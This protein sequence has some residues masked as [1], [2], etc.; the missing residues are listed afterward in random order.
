[1]SLFLGN[2]SSHVHPDE[3]ERVFRRFG[4][5]DVQLK[6]GYGFAV[7]E[8]PENAERA[9]RALRGKQICGQSIAIDWSKKQPRPPFQR[10]PR[11]RRPYEPNHGRSFHEEDNA[12]SYRREEKAASTTKDAGPR[13]EGKF[14]RYEP[15][16][17]T[18][19][20][21]GEKARAQPVCY[22][23]GLKG[24]K[25]RFCP[26]ADRSR[27]DGFA[28]FWRREDSLSGPAERTRES[29]PEEEEEEEESHKQRKKSRK[30]R[31]FRRGREQSSEEESSSSSGSV[32]RRRR[33]SKAKTRSLSASV[34]DV[35]AGSAAIERQE[36]NWEE[37]LTKMSFE[38][39]CAAL[40]HYYGSPA[41]AAAATSS[42]VGRYFGAARLWPWEMVFYRRLKKDPPSPQHR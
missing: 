25:M 12:R 20:S 39:M 38:E 26:R 21:P 10:P 32:T 11:E 29:S 5:C 16:Q 27:R 15:A 4:Y 36:D 40:R 9:L 24:H 1:M 8:L 13:E 35:E 19:T 30:R 23:C 7:Y 2:L 18:E 14:E 42:S 37:R 33:R 28:R 6:D 34:D 31:K 3:L 17:V 22:I 41:A